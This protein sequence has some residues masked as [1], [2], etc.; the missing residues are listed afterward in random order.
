MLSGNGTI[1]Y[2]VEAH[3]LDVQ[4]TSA[5]RQGSTT[6]NIHGSITKNFQKTFS[7]VSPRSHLLR[8]VSAYITNKLYQVRFFYNLLSIY[9]SHICSR[10]H[11]YN[12]SLLSLFDTRNNCSVMPFPTFIVVMLFASWFS[13]SWVFEHSQAL[14][15]VVLGGNISKFRQKHSGRKLTP[16]M[17]R[18]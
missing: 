15:E 1:D 2:N 12:F 8:F 6:R 4:E 5:A 13:I 11:K 10:C 14:G 16:G 9:H 7:S 3:T 17:W 18:T